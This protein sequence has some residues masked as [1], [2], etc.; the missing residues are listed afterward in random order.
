MFIRQ[1]SI[2][3][4]FPMGRIRHITFLGLL[5]ALL[6]EQIH[7]RLKISWS[8][9]NARDAPKDTARV[10]ARAGKATLAPWQTWTELGAWQM[11]KKIGALWGPLEA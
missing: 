4:T 11:S 1:D 8:S 6:E 3:C 10:G 5:S 2:L 7:Q 9:P